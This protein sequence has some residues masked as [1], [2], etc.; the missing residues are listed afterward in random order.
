MSDKTQFVFSS[1]RTYIKQ[2]DKVAGT[3]YTIDYSSGGFGYAKAYFSSSENESTQI[4]YLPPPSISS[5]VLDAVLEK[6]TLK[7]TFGGSN[8]NTSSPYFSIYAAT[9][10]ISTKAESGFNTLQNS[11]D[12]ITSFKPN[13]SGSYTLPSTAYSK[14]KTKIRNAL[15]Y[16]IFIKYSTV[17]SSNYRAIYALSGSLTADLEY[18]T[19]NSPPNVIITSPSYSDIPEVPITDGY[20]VEWDYVQPAGTQQ[21][22]FQLLFK[23]YPI[24]NEPLTELTP[25]YSSANTTHFITPEQMPQMREYYG[26]VALW[27]KAYINNNTIGSELS[28]SGEYGKRDLIL[29]FPRPY[30][31]T[32]SDQAI[33]LANETIVLKWKI[34]YSQGADSEPI[35]AQNYPSIFDIEFSGNGG[36]TWEQ[37][38]HKAYVTRNNDVYSYNVP[39]NTFTPGIVQWRVRAYVGDKT[40]DTY[41]KAVVTSR[42]QASTSSVSADGKPR[43]T[44]SWTASSQVAYQVKFADYDSGAIY[45][46]NTSHTVPYFYADGIYPVQVRTQAANGVWSN[47]TDIE[48]VNV[49]NTV[50]TGRVILSVQNT[51]HTVNA[52]WSIGGIFEKYILYRNDIPVYIGTQTEYTDIAAHGLCTYYVRAISGVDYVQSETVSVNSIP[53]TDCLYNMIAGIW[54]P[55][56]YSYRPQIR[57][58]SEKV[59][60]IYKYYSGRTLPVAYT[61]QS[62]ER[63][64][65]A[66]FVFKTRAEADMLKNALGQLVIFKD[67]RGGRI[68]G[69]LD[70][71]TWNVGKRFEATIQIVEVDYKEKI[72]YET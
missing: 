37:L 6:L 38:D 40:I 68:I 54:I 20:Q 69:F 35:T 19:S 13:Q 32:P 42:V 29:Y 65:S 66:S 67:T 64:L 3:N 30:E 22:G 23:H 2:V 60:A 27:V 72:P 56:K 44:I 28:D 25:L 14:D 43:P 5:D 57:S 26:A 41:E 62:K 11:G 21:S 7:A 9:S 53:S 39:P 34:K 1:K 15:R 24:A 18:S 4:L 8:N 36:E 61:D 16:G 12:F 47:W 59:N 33:V 31:L 51:R 71:I 55:L 10:D 58:Y 45:S 50:I 48:Y 70:N 46:D 49:K 17:V 63:I 52:R